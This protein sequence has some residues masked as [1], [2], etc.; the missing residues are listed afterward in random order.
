[1]TQK[2]QTQ[3]LIIV[4]I[5]A[6]FLG[7][8]YLGQ[9]RIKP[10]PTPPQPIITPSPSPS[11]ET[12]NWKTYTS[13]RYNFTFRYPIQAKI[14]EPEGMVGLSVWGPTQVKDTDFYDGISLRFSSGSLES[15]SLKFFVEEKVKQ[16][17]ENAEIIV[18][19][20]EIKV[21]NLTGYTYRV[22]G[23]GEHTYI[24]LTPRYNT[25]LEIINSTVD[26][27]NRGYQET[28]NQ[29]LSTFKFLP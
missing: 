13:T 16:S 6:V 11:D 14:E 28:V 4:V 18:N 26:P 19:P 12:A 20:T 15:K 17:K 25:Y 24:Y 23:L 1:M 22:R 7:G 21:G 29:I 8:Y 5:L 10:T 2:G 27:G 3:V 9:Q